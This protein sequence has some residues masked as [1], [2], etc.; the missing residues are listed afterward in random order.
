MPLRT[1]IGWCGVV[2]AILAVARLMAQGGAYA[3]AD[4]DA[5]AKLYGSQCVT[6]H[7]ADGTSIGGVDLG[8][9]KFRRA[10]SDQE[11]MSVI[12][13]G[14][15]DAGMPAHDFSQAQLVG[16]VAYLRN[17]HNAAGMGALGDARLGQQVVEGKG[18]CLSCHR[19]NGQGSR[20]APDLSTVGAL[21]SADL[22]RRSLVDPKSAL[23]PIN[24]AVR[25]V[26]KD[27]TVV[28]GRRLNEDTFTMQLADDSGRL[29]S[30]VKAELREYAVS[31]D[32]RMPSY[33]GKLTAGEIG[34]VLAYLLTL[35]GA[36]R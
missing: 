18:G 12:K 26:M 17:M 35:K 32:A 27:G 3:Q 11:L 7:G 14:I 36:Q 15:P 20:A 5:G 33:Q 16:L 21:R 19:V 25:A 9:N 30:L 2:G 1:T 10:T 29:V 22:L 13:G 31:T 4:I 6:C 28:T 24:Q 23:I 8:S 34:D